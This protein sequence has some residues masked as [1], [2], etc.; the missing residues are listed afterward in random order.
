MNKKLSLFAILVFLISS[1]TVFAKDFT[2]D[3]NSVISQ[4]NINKGAIS[5]S[6]QD[7]EDKKTC[8]E[9][10]QTIPRPPASIQKLIT[11]LPAV[12]I[13]GEN[14]NFE[15]KLYKN[16]IGNYIIALGADPYLKYNDLKNLTKKMPAEVKSIYIDDSIIDAQ[17]WGEGWQWDDD[18]NPLMPKF[19]AYNID[20]NT[21]NIFIEP[22]MEN[23]PANIIFEKDYPTS[24]INN[25][26]T[27]NKTEYK[28]EKKS[29]EAPDIITATGVINKTV[30]V[31][32]PVNSPK[33]YFKLRLTDALLDNQKSNSGIFYN[34]KL[35]N[36]Y[37]LVDKVSHNISQAKIDILKNSDNYVSETLF[38]LAGG[39]YKNTTGSFEAGKEMFN[40]YCKKMNLDNSHINIMDASGVSKNNLMNTD[41]MINYLLINKD[42]LEPIMA[43]S[44]EGT[45]ADRLLYL[46]GNIKAKTGTLA[47][48]STI[49][50]FVSTQNGHKYVF[51][52]MIQ[53]P[54][55]DNK[56]KKLLEDNIIKTLYL[57]G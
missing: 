1:N 38:K 10:N 13:L 17:E 53:D 54:K 33:K 51:C 36:D 28:I 14:Y 16:K 11:T 48:I 12:E 44:G 52:I 56:D 43:T 50:G 4:S 23:A 5:I 32:I 37:Y 9:L 29:Y 2:K 39:K 3:L 6:I 45:M 57:K 27:G 41:F 15:T 8:Y 55:S 22:T 30:T 42:Q 46:K 49:T 7:I 18:I 31:K 47:N 24:F 34:K 21:I 20:R 25:V 40:D 19:S 26:I 35:T